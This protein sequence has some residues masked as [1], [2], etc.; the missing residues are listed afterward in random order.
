MAE[1]SMKLVKV[2]V[3]HGRSIHVNGSNGEQPRLIGPGRVVEVEEWDI[4]RLV[5]GKFIVDPHAKKKTVAEIEE[6]DFNDAALKQAYGLSMAT[7]DNAEEGVAD[8]KEDGQ[9]SLKKK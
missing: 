8:V 2:V 5:K 9:V 6:T 1:K 3:A 4:P 7:Q